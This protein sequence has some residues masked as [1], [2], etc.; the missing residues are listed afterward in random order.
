MLV[1][2]SDLHLKDGTSG[3]S[4][5]ADAC[6]VFAGRLRDQ[7]YRASHRTGS[8]SYR[9]IEVIDLVL[10]GDVFDQIRSVKWLEEDGR[11]V[12]I[13]PWD[14]PHS[15]EFIRKIQTI[16]DYTAEQ[17]E[18]EI[19]LPR[20]IYADDTI[21]AL[22]AFTDC[23]VAISPNLTVIHNNQPATLTISDILTANTH[24]LRNNLEK[25]LRIDLDRQQERLQAHLLE[26][27]F[28][29]ERLYKQIEECESYELVVEAVAESLIPFRKKLL[30]DVT[31][32]DIERLLEIKIRRI[33]KYDLAKKQKDIRVL[34][35]KIK[36]INQH[37]KDMTL[38]TINYIDG[39]LSK[40]GKEYPRKTE[41]SAFREVKA[42]RVAI[43]NL[44]I[45]YQ[46]KTGFLGH[47]VKGDEGFSFNCSEY[48]KILLIFKNGTYKIVPIVDKLFLDS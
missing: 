1:I 38:F 26:Q 9:P 6:N 37:L 14:D 27:I 41:L 36:E 39:L 44:T 16:N 10:L 18:I 11:P 15:P 43:S 45:G 24:D 28:I 7:A 8:K 13:R 19:K 46:A 33:S 2:I 17:V 31:L 22:Y 12:S 29:E 42:R 3:T 47:Q 30:R 35:K 48:D 20:G 4:I 25:E 21:K 5:T 23:E 34:R 40:Y 32:E